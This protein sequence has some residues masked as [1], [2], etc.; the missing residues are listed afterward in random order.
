MLPTKNKDDL[1]P[2]MKEHNE[3]ELKELDK[4]IDGIKSIIRLCGDD[5]NREGLVDTPFRVLKAFL[6][7]TSGIKE[8]PSKHLETQ[9]NVKHS[10]E[11][12]LIKD[13][14]FFSLCEHHFA[15]F[16][17]VAHVAYIPSDTV[18]GLSKIGRLVDE[19]SKRFQV[20]ERLSD[21]IV[22]I[23]FNTLKPLGCIV[24]IEATHMCMCSRGVKK[25]NS[26]TVT[27]AS[28]GLFVDDEKL[29]SEFLMLLN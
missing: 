8:N 6:E 21:E 19:L 29:R 3:G 13:I 18:T 27:I 11:I 14:E 17:G 5:P 12:V 9:F 20:Q 28:R 16:F 25:S 15:P 7:N 24:K 2:Y 10:K 22:E 1:I 23:I 26:K 4:A